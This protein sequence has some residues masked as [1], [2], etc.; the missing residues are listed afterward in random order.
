LETYIDLVSAVIGV[1]SVFR[2]SSGK[3]DALPASDFSE[4]ETS[5]GTFDVCDTVPRSVDAV[6]L[7]AGTSLLSEYDG[8]LIF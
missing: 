1:S 7:A 8:G 6:E 3:V 4:E 2:F 5:E